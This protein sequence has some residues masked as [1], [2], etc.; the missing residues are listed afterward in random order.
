MP[1]N[2][3]KS[4]ER[5]FPQRT[6]CL[7]CDLGSRGRYA[8]W[9][10][11]SQRPRYVGGLPCQGD[12]GPSRC[13]V[14]IVMRITCFL[15]TP[16][17]RLSHRCES[18]SGHLRHHRRVPQRN[19]DV[20]RAKE[21]CRAWNT[22]LLHHAFW[23]IPAFRS[24]WPQEHYVRNVVHRRV[25][26]GELSIGGYLGREACPY[27]KSFFGQSSTHERVLQLRCYIPLMFDQG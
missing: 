22:H 6:K 3:P 15:K 7:L 25:S 14:Q 26:T 4:L 19:F 24:H 11:L 5:Q 18:L 20:S 21:Q 17:N 13:V 1:L 8:K 2:G 12:H 23:L 16:R 9:R 10:H 27:I